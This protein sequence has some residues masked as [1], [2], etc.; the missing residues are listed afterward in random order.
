MGSR[1]SKVS[2]SML[3]V[4]GQ[5]FREES[6]VLSN[7]IFPSASPVMSLVPRS[8]GCGAVPEN[9]FMTPRSLGRSAIYNMARAPY[10][11]VHSATTSKVYLRLKFISDL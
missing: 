7:Q 10:S 2:P 11:R 1:P 9:G 3:G 4:R 8:S 6:T 5:A